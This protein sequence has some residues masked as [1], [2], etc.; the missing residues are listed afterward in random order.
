MHATC[1]T[2]LILLHLITL[3]IFGEV[4]KSTGTVVL[5]L[6]LVTPEPVDKF[7][8]NLVRISCLWK[9][10]YLYTFLF[11]AISKCSW[12]MVAMPICEMEMMLLPFNI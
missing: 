7:S 11:P 2:H 9:L 12:Y 5:V 6:L 1:S 8:Q 10:L 3:I 4:Y